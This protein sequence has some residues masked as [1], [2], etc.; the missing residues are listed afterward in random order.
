MD[1][2]LKNSM[3]V[4]AKATEFLSPGQTPVITCDQPL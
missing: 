1:K 2:F 3:M 4:I